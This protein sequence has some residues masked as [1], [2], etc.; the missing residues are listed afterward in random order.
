MY[1]EKFSRLG[2]P[3]PAEVINSSLVMARYLIREMVG[4]TI[5]AIGEPP[6]LAELTAASLRLSEIWTIIKSCTPL[7]I[8]PNS[9]SDK[10]VAERF[11]SQLIQ[12]LMYLPVD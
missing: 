12:W 11:Q 3:P 4:A 5:F 10:S 2:I 8:P 9:L 7:F 6:L 1:A